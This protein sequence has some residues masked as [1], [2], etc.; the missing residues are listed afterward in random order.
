[1]GSISNQKYGKR[2]FI[3]EI[4]A[5]ISNFFPSVSTETKEETYKTY[6]LIYAVLFGTGLLLVLIFLNQLLSFNTTGVFFL[7]LLLGGFYLLCLK[8][9]VKLV[10]IGN[11]IALGF[12][13]SQILDAVN[14]G[15]IFYLGI[16]WSILVP[17]VAF[18]FSNIKSG[19][20]WTGMIIVYAFVLYYL[21]VDAAQSAFDVALK[22]P[23]FYLIA[24]V[25][26]YLY[27]GMI[28][29]VFKRGNDLIIEELKEQKQIVKQQQL[30]LIEKNR[31]LEEAKSKLLQQNQELEQ[32]AFA[33][34]HD[35]KSPLRSITSFTQLLSRHLDKRSWKDEQTDSYLKFIVNGSNNMNVFIT[36]LLNYASL[37]TGEN[38]YVTTDLN[39]VLIAVKESLYEAIQSTETT[40]LCEQLPTIAVV[41][42][43]IN[44]LFQN[45][46]SNAIKFRKADEL[47]E[48]EISAKKLTSSWEFRIKDNG[49]GI[50]KEDQQGIFEPFKKLHSQDKYSGSGIGLST[51]RKIVEMHKGKIWVESTMGKG[52]SFYFSLSAEL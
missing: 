46:I 6:V 31:V 17:M 38:S 40:I 9:N 23:E 29:A 44:Q 52:T 1:M 33:T 32:F 41:P 39:E 26:L 27:V 43:K 25:G 12:F 8:L 36:D 22:T 30:S 14:S 50:E 24:A 5:I 34:S 13:V 42:A 28:L 47:L 2:N 18:C 19:I 48:L 45:L 51:C 7:A 21:E 4:H 16:F 15:G 10:Y 37:G 49:I 11:I 3:N 20:F 35:L